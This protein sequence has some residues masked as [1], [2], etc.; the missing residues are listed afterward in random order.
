MTETETLE[1]SKDFFDGV[2]GI[3]TA[4]FGGLA[5]LLAGISALFSGLNKKSSRSNGLSLE[6][7]AREMRGANAEQ[8][9]A[10][11]QISRDMNDMRRDFDRHQATSTS[12]L[13]GLEKEMLGFRELHRMEA[14]VRVMAAGLVNVNEEL[15]TIRTRN[16]ERDGQMQ[17]LLTR[18]FT[19]GVAKGR[20]DKADAK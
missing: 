12:R 8:N 4:T 1:P 18:S 14:D 10:L 6:G 19:E 3:L 15:K 16:H 11:K 17:T 2:G 20:S 13:D 5:A 7:F 9:Q